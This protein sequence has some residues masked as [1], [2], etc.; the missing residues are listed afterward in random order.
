[1]SRQDVM[2]TDQ[3]LL[4]ATQI[5]YCNVEE[6]DI[7]CTLQEI[8]TRHGDSFYYDQEILK[9]TNGDKG[10]MA[11]EAKQF[12]ADVAAGKICQGW[13]LVSIGD[14]QGKSGMF[15]LT[16][17]TGENE[18][19]VAFRGSESVNVD[20]TIKDW[21]WA[22]FCS[23]N[24]QA[25]VQEEMAYQYLAEV[26]SEFAYENLTLT[27]HSLGGNLSHVA[28]VYAYENDQELYSRIRQS[29][30]FDGPGHPQEYIQEHQKAIDAVQDKL[31]HYQWSFVGTILTSFCQGDNYQSVLSDKFSKEFLA[32]FL[33]HSTASLRFHGS[34]LYEIEGFCMS[35]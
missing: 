34:L 23:I 31:T 3:E 14:D 25:T 13:K 33:K 24:A 30:S 32:S 10:I 8:F 29:V 5:A 22:D 1:M 15:A 35:A 9:E 17:E 28:A 7:G 4:W 19:I 20:Q 16:I 18:A 12:I 11:K 21:G 26:G 6:R 2:Y 27:G